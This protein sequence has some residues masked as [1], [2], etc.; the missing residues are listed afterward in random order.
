MTVKWY[1]YNLVTQ[2]QTI[3]TPSSENAFFPA[4]NLKKDFSSKVYRS[5]TDSAQVVFDFI[6]IEPIDSVLIKAHYELGRGFNGSLT[7]EANGT[8]EWTSPAFTTTIDLVDQFNIGKTEFAEQNYRFWRVSGSGSNYLELANIFIGKSVSLTTNNIDFGWKHLKKDLSKSKENQYGQ[9]FSNKRN[10]VDDI[11]ASYKLLNRDEYDVI[12]DMINYHGT[13]IPVW[14]YIDDTETII[15]N[16][17]RF[18]GQ[19]YFTRSPSIT[20]GS[21]RLY[22]LNLRL[23]ETV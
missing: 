20:N 16:K 9:R 11:S 2:D 22:D 5:T 17:E 19:Y 8:D 3:I 10:K 4:S 6:T 14:A 13:T 1:S 12:V 23:K 15:N 21:F 7:I 18:A